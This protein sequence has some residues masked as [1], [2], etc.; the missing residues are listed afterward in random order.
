MCLPKSTV[1][2]SILGVNKLGWNLQISSQHLEVVRTCIRK[3]EQMRQHQHRETLR[4][5]AAEGCRA[6]LSC[7]LLPALDTAATLHSSHAYEPGLNPSR[8]SWIPAVNELEGAESSAVASGAIAASEGGFMDVVSGVWSVCARAVN[9]PEWQAWERKRSRALEEAY[10]QTTVHERDC[11][12]AHR[13]RDV[14]ESAT[15]GKPIVAV[16][17]ANHVPGI[18]A[19]WERAHSP[20]FQ[21]QCADYLT[22]PNMPHPPPHAWK[23]KAVEFLATAFEGVAVVAGTGVLATAARRY[24]SL[25]HAVAGTAVAGG[26]LAWGVNSWWESYRRPAYLV[27]N[28]ARYNDAAQSAL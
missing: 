28:L 22:V 19:A 14:A 18:M 7:S 20:E 23:V 8:W 13:I 25:N 24:M 17:G 4:Q 27:E 1:S 3:V 5:A 12:L 9:L 16:V 15:P 6:N 10:L 26:A 2:D 11:I 21:Q